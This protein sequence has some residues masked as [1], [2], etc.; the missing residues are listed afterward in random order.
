VGDNFDHDVAPA[1][2]RLIVLDQI[3]DERR[4]LVAQRFERRGLSIQP[5]K[6]AALGPPNGGLRVPGRPH[7]N[8]LAHGHSPSV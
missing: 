7:N 5:G 4:Q 1:Q 3:A 6:I 2:C 8:Q